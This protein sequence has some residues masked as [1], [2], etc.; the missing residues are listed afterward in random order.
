MFRSSAFL[1]EVVDGDRVVDHQVH[2]HQRLDLL[3]VLAHLVGDVAHGG[4]VGQQRHAGEVLQHHAGDDERD[5][6]DALG[7]GA[8]VGQ[9]LD[10]FFGDLLAVAVA[11]HRFQHDADRHRQA[12]DFRAQAFSSAGSE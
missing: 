6:I 5:L 1:A 8:P 2:R 11:Q 12:R 3:G 10:V 4:Q 7:G 9:L